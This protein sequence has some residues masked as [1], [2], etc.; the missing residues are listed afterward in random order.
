MVGGLVYRGAFQL[1]LEG[2]LYRMINEGHA[3]LKA[4]EQTANELLN[5]MDTGPERYDFIES[6]T[7]DCDVTSN[8]FD[9]ENVSN[10]KAGSAAVRQKEQGHGLDKS[11]TGP[12]KVAVDQKGNEKWA[13]PRSRAGSKALSSSG[14]SSSNQGKT[15]ET[16]Q[17]SL[18]G[19]TPG[20][21]EEA[22]SSM[23]RREGGAFCRIHDGSS[24]GGTDDDHQRSLGVCLHQVLT[25]HERACAR[26]AN[27]VAE[28]EG[29]NTALAARTAEAVK[30]EGEAMAQTRS[31]EVKHGALEGRLA[32]LIKLSREELDSANKRV[33][34]ERSRSLDLTDL[35]KETLEKAT[36]I[37]LDMVAGFAPRDTES[38]GVDLFR[39]LGIDP[40]FYSHLLATKR[41]FEV[42]CTCAIVAMEL[43]IWC[44]RDLDKPFSR[45][46]SSQNDSCA[47]VYYLSCVMT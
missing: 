28:L 23:R 12:S 38:L 15:K 39:S 17:A 5:S 3:T 8:N 18:T 26:Y 32:D 13:T 36:P 20:F 42:G 21:V 2:T 1:T 41:M 31:W 25:T 44:C 37:L 47:V 40:D 27:Q 45:C 30:L 29:Q 14:S 7:V 9:D 19:E 46:R 11:E 22:V 4:A 35:L 34:E 24:G 6:A 43:V 33:D 16:K 10:S